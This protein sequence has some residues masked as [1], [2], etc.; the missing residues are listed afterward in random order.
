MFGSGCA[1]SL[2][3]YGSMFRRACTARVSPSRMKYAPLLL[4]IA[5]L[6]LPSRVKIV[7]DPQMSTSVSSAR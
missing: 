7:G 4:P 6:V 3:L 2:F 1:G 5:T